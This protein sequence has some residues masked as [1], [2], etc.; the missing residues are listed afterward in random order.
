MRSAKCPNGATERA[1]RRLTSLAGI[2]LLLDDALAKVWGGLTTIEEVLRVTHTDENDGAGPS[3][4]AA[5]S[6]ARWGGASSS[7]RGSS[8]LTAS[9]RPA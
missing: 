2:R 5:C 4:K 3:P 8:G 6:T 1:L 9:K 7:A